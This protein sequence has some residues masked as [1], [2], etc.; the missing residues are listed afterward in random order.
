MGRTGDGLLARTEFGAGKGNVEVRVLGVA[1]GVFGVLEINGAVWRTLGAL[2][3]HEAVALLGVD[4]GDVAFFC[5]EIKRHLLTLIIV[6]P[7]C[8]DRRLDEV[9]QCVDGALGVHQC[10]VHIHRNLS[11]FELHVE[12]VH[13]GLPI[14]QSQSGLGVV[15]Q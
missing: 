6:A 14:E 9:A 15:N 5:F 13:L 3:L 10:A 11:R 1:G 8:I 7:L 4:V 12:I 2:T